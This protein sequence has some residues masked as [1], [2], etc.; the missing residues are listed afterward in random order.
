MA[1][2]KIADIY[3]GLW[4]S[5]ALIVFMSRMR[6]RSD[7]SGT[8]FGRAWF[9]LN[10]LAHMLIYYFLIVVI[11]RR[12]GKTVNPFVMILTGITHYW[13][14]RQALLDSCA[15]ITSND[16]LLLQVALEPMVL[17]GVSF[18]VNLRNFAISF[19]L[20]FAIYFI[21]DPVV[22]VRMLCYP[23]VLAMMIVLAWSAC[24][25]LA[26]LTVFFRD[27]RFICSVL[28]RM[29]M[30]LAPV[31]YPLSM[32]PERLQR[33]YLFNPLACL[34][35][36]VQWCL[37]GQPLPAVHH[38]LTLVLFVIFCFV[39]AHYVYALLRVKLT[40]AL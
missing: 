23:V 7:V 30:Y 38:I 39:F 35:G 13:F 29:F 31:V 18:V 1:R 24:V 12:G 32:V 27:L 37:I 8:T 40:K 16:R 4:G 20:Y 25:L 10:P 15:A 17:S 6:R 19:V 11:F 22:S 5:R 14:F 36:L 21:V 2:L 28:L 9:V 3:S 26:C 33:F 34:F